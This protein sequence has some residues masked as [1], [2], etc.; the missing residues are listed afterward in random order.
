MDNNKT[1]ERFNNEIKSY[2]LSLERLHDHYIEGVKNEERNIDKILI[3]IS[4]GAITIIF[5]FISNAPKNIFVLKWA[6]IVGVVFFLSTIVSVIVSKYLG[7]RA[8][9]AGQEYYLTANDA[10]R[11]FLTDKNVD[12]YKKCKEKW[13]EAE[14][15]QKR[16]NRYTQYINFLS[17]GLLFVSLVLA[18]LFI[19]F[20]I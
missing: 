1:L 19:C 14:D 10:C 6:M 4:A 3:T 17:V 11:S 15:K 18:G 8:N 20:N 5:G 7:I 9:F 2:L 13:E 12:N 16:F